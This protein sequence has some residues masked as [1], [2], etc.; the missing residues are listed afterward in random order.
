MERRD[1]WKR[2]LMDGDPSNIHSSNHPSFVCVFACRQTGRFG[3]KQVT[4]RFTCFLPTERKIR[5]FC[6][7]IYHSTYM[8]E[9]SYQVEVYYKRY[10]V[11]A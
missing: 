6:N 3:M 7:V 4:M 11:K 5:T 10:T 2:E 1:A 8:F 9:M